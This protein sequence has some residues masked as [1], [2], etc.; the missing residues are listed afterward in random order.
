MSDLQSCEQFWNKQLHSQLLRTFGAGASLFSN[1]QKISS[2]THSC[3]AGL[4]ALSTPLAANVCPSCVKKSQNIDICV[5]CQRLK[6]LYEMFLFL[7]RKRGNFQ[8]G[9]SQSALLVPGCVLPLIIST[10]RWNI[11]NMSLR[12]VSRL[13]KSLLNVTSLFLWAPMTL[14][15]SEI[16]LC[17]QWKSQPL[18]CCP[19]QWTISK[20]VLGSHIY[21]CIVDI[22]LS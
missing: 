19:S 5:I 11:C 10:D 1:L 14:K 3:A 21:E 8:P 7:L 20:A 18:P 16:L 6:Y 2:L 15:I 9:P 4:I 22:F 13:H 12:I 17:S